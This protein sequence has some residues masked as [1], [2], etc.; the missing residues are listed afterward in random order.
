MT[1]EKITVSYDALTWFVCSPQKKK[2]L[3]QIKFK[4]PDTI[5]TV[6]V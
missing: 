2:K 6:D 1:A 3:M 5:I 4:L